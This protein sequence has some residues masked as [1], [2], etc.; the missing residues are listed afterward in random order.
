MSLPTREDI[1]PW[2]DET[3]CQTACEHYLGKSLEEVAA[4]LHDDYWLYGEDLAYMGPVAFRFYLPAVAQVLRSGS[5]LV[6]W[7]AF[8]LR[9]R[10]EGEPHELLPIAEQLVALCDEVVSCWV[11]FHESGTYF[12]LNQSQVPDDNGEWRKACEG[13]FHGIEVR[14]GCLRGEFVRLSEGAQVERDQST[15]SLPPWDFLW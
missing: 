5:P 10:L 2:N 6:D 4:M 11:H 15:R 8:V 9:N 14:Y 13:L 7:F 1:N 12:G 3:D